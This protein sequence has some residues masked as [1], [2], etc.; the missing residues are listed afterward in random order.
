MQLNQVYLNIRGKV[1]SLDG[2]AKLYGKFPQ[3]DLPAFLSVRR[4]KEA[5]VNRRSASKKTLPSDPSR[6]MFNS[7]KFTARLPLLA[8]NRRIL[9]T[10][11]LRISFCLHYIL[12]G[13]SLESAGW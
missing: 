11:N 9:G 4:V 5:M 8:F 6:D 2:V 1:N 13:D 12:G 10:F 7:W 3:V